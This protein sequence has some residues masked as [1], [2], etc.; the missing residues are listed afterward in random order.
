MK[1]KIDHTESR[2]TRFNGGVFSSRTEEWETP[3]YV[4]DAL[5]A[6]FDFQLDVCATEENKK[7]ARYF[8]K[9]ADGLKQEWSP[10]HCFMNP[11]YG[12]E[13]GLWM[14]RA[15]E[16]SLTGGIVVCLVHA[17]T[18]T[19]WWHDWAMK[20]SEIRFVKGRLKFG[21]GKQ[22]APFPSC[23]VVFRELTNKTNIYN[24]PICTSVKFNPR[25]GR[26]T[27][28]FS[29]EPVFAGGGHRVN[30]NPPRNAETPLN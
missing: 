6:E 15:Y 20:A 8:D 3:Q 21:D 10:Y 24:S 26:H 12:K 27:E 18:D 28:M 25:G 7:C 13:I 30:E 4:F 14:R 16:Q 29:A 5:N 11:P 22:S 17:R 9:P 2:T 1:R 23:I 19:R